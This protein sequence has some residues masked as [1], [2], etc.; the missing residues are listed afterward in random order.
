MVIGSLIFP[1][2]S[3]LASSYTLGGGEVTNLLPPR[4]WS[5]QESSFLSFLLGQII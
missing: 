4:V 5:W 3:L 2:L 1:R